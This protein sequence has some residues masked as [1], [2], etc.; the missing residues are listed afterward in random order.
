MR[1]KVDTI[2]HNIGELVTFNNTSPGDITED[3]AGILRDAA[4]A[5]SNGV[6]LDVGDTNDILRRYRGETVDAQGNLVTPGLIDTHTHMVFSGSRE[7]EFEYKIMG[8]SYDEIQERGGGIYRT[9]RATR[10]ASVSDLVAKG[11]G[12]LGEM[13][14]HGSTV[15]EIKGGYGLDLDGELKIMEAA[16]LISERTPVKIIP[17]MQAHIIPV[18]YR[19]DRRAYIDYY[20][21]K[22][23]PEASKRNLA[24]YSDVFCD[25]GAFTPIETRYILE[26]SLELGFR[27]R[28]HA[29]QLSYIGC[30]E[31]ARDLP[32][33]AMDHLDHMPA[34]N[35]RVMAEKGLA[36]GLTPTSEL[37]MF[38]ENL[39]PVRELKNWKVPIAL[40]T[41]YNPN[42]MTPNIQLV[43]D[44]ST[45]KYR[46]TPLEALAGATINA[47]YSLRLHDRR[48]RIRKGYAADIVV[49]RIPNHKWIG[50]LWGVN[51][52][53]KVYV[54]GKEIWG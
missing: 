27:L 24:V 44:L 31:L 54:S 21:N 32:L 53:E 37:A 49:W 25:K 29:D 11:L 16:K 15:V 40:G 46:L 23:L 3:K 17:T 35:T 5:V 12:V 19:G 45:Y 2:I 4:I 48:G 34:E 30:S 51:K 13:I 26:K 41:D 43:M 38:S 20:V 18:E 28:I 42:N 7:D 10:Q 52:V 8:L 50:Y 39:P 1:E 6:I 33:D 14:R 36:A 47:A 22:T 9:V